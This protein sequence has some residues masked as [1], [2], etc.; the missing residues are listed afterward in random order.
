MYGDSW[1]KKMF[2]DLDVEGSLGGGRP[3]KTWD[4]VVRGGLKA[5]AIHRDLAQDR[6][7]W[8][9]DII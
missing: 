9:K 2:R 3:R 1:V 6:V 8:K 7:A 4:E 5:E